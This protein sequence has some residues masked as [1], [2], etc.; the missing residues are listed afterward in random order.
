MY[1][2]QAYLKANYRC[3]FMA[4]LLESVKSDKDKTALY[5]G[6]CRR[7]GI[8][9]LP[10]DVNESVGMFTPVGQDI[11]YGLAAVR[12]VGDNVVKGVVD[13]RTEHGLSLIHI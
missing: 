4:A 7:M 5:L 11:R 3:E 8:R 10:P 13:A 12:N 9:V 2:R 1:K 6:E